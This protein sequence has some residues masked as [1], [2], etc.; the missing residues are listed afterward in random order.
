MKF[1]RVE[2]AGGLQPRL[3]PFGEAAGQVSSQGNLLEALGIGGS[4][5]DE[6]PAIFINHVGFGSF[7]H[8]G[9]QTLGLVLD[10]LDAVVDGRT[11]HCRAPAAKGPN[12][13]LYLVGVSV[14]Y[15]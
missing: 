7:K 15:L 10:L 9:R 2:E 6:K 3:H 8:V 5:L 14:N 1:P 11:T 12:P 13:E 4:A